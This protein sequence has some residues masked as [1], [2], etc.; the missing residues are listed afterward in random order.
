MLSEAKRS[1]SPE[2]LNRLDQML[3]FHPLEQETLAEITRQLLEET[4]K[5]LSGL[6]VSME[7]EDGAVA[8]L[9]REGRSRDYGARP[10]RRAVAAWVEDP[11][12]DLLLGGDLTA[13]G[14]IRVCAQGEQVR[15]ELV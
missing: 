11:A 2:F 14:A 1:F 6:G 10:L 12:A 7:V 13:G 4:Q 8:L 9:A 5:R 15:V 3:V